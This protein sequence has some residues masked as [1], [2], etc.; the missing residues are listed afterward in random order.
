MSP[1]Y[2]NLPKPGLIISVTGNADPFVEENELAAHD[3]PYLLFKVPVP[4]LE[5]K[6]DAPC[7]LFVPVRRRQLGAPLGVVDKPSE[8]SPCGTMSKR[9]HLSD[10]LC[11]IADFMTQS[12]ADYATWGKLLVELSKQLN[13]SSQTKQIDGRLKVTFSVSVENASG[14]K[15]QLSFAVPPEQAKDEAGSKQGQ[16]DAEQ[17]KSK[18]VAGYK[19]DREDRFE[20]F[21]N[22][23]NQLNILSCVEVFL[24]ECGICNSGHVCEIIN[25]I[26]SEARYRSGSWSCDVCKNQMSP[27]QANVWHCSTC[28]FD[29]CPSCQPGLLERQRSA[30]QSDSEKFPKDL[31]ITKLLEDKQVFDHSFQQDSGNRVEKASANQS[32]GN[33]TSNSVAQDQSGQRIGIKLEMSSVTTDAKPNNCDATKKSEERMQLCVPVFH[34]DKLSDVQRRIENLSLAMFPGHDK[35]KPGL[36]TEQRAKEITT[37]FLTLPQPIWQKSTLILQQSADSG[38]QPEQLQLLKDEDEFDKIKRGEIGSKRFVLLRTQGSGCHLTKQVVQRILH[39]VAFLL[40]LQFG[41]VWV[42][43]GGTNKGIMQVHRAG[44]ALI[45]LPPHSLPPAVRQCACV[46]I[47]QRGGR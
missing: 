2:W 8:C 12:P 20:E 11:R 30:Q 36:V 23:L 44:L 4:K 32:S 19:Q 16:K 43:S 46:L 15:E 10:V 9:D 45:V 24:T 25:G 29:V 1:A 39:Q 37:R 26:P 31:K 34:S 42:I 17:P 22:Q 27:A 47:R 38:G 41:S 18:D 5:Q 40:P 28:A 6:A 14:K 7:S 21:M 35:P 33:A 3:Q 13:L